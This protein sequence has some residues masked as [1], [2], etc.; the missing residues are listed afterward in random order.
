LR[1]GEGIVSLD[2]LTLIG[3]IVS[4][5]GFM[6]VELLW[7][8]GRAMPQVPHWRLIG[9][10]GFVV[11]M[12]LFGAA[13]LFIL[14]LLSGLHL[15][16]LSHWGGWGAIPVVV[17]TTFFTYWSHRIQHRFDLL[18]RMGHQFHHGVARVDIAS[19]FIFHPV[20]VLVQAFWTLL[21]STLL[22]ITPVAGAISAVLGA[23][24]ALYQHWNVDTRRWTN[25]IFQRP[26]A[27][28]LHHEL[29]VHARN[30]GDMPVWDMLF[31]T[32][33]NPAHSDDVRVGFEAGRARRWL[34][35]LA[36][37]DVNEAQGR[38]RL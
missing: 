31:G 16:D 5:F 8:A 1:A 7:P 33:E 17:L 12:L 32:Y 13:P 14:P 2:E 36:F 19:A 28:M 20:D 24:P 37:V 27:H 26:E 3:L 21:A 38:K 29:D 22:G 30:F 4:F 11:T 23:W 9:V 15:L 6:L 35:M 10:V 18:W 34:A 25:W